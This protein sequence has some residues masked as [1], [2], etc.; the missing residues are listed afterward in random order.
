[1]NK[2]SYTSL[3]NHTFFSNT[4]GVRDAISSPEES[5]NYAFEMGLNGIVFTEHETL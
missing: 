3:H 2:N 4:H 5:L 1:M